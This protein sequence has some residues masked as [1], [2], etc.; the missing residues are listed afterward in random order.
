MVTK[1]TPITDKNGRQTTVH[2]KA[3]TAVTGTRAAAIAP[4]AA[5]PSD[6]PLSTE[7][8]RSAVDSIPYPND[9]ADRDERNRIRT[10]NSHAVRALEKRWGAWLADEY[11]SEV[12]AAAHDD[13][14]RLAWEQGHSSG[15]GEVEYHYSEYAGLAAKVAQA[16]RAE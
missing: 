13:I 7:E 12:P 6:S 1:P 14:Y 11:A 15:Y 9:T 10:E 2:K 5:T 4:V 8:L 3:D 16:V